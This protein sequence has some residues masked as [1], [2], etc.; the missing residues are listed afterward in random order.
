MADNGLLKLVEDFDPGDIELGETIELEE[1]FG[2]EI[3]EIDW[4]SA[5]GIMY[6]IWI[7]KRRDDPEFT[8]EDAR[9]IKWNELQPPEEDADPPTPIS[10]A[11]LK[12][13]RARKS[14]GERKRA[15]GGTRR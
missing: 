13:G 7:A 5:K 6:A 11:K 1:A 4:N 2:C 9:K 12:D 10:N 15:S 3:G 8:I 14:G